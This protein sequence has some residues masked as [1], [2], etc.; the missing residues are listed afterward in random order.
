MNVKRAAFNNGTVPRESEH[1][2][3]PTTSKL[4]SNGQLLV[5]TN[6]TLNAKYFARPDNV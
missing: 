2:K 3:R 1:E 5:E 4:E 6:V